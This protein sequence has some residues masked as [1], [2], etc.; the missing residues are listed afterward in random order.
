MQ[1]H[2][3]ENALVHATL[4]HINIM[5]MMTMMTLMLLMMMMMM[6]LVAAIPLIAVST[7]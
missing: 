5:V 6:M 1:R 7:F 4:I 2:Q 3:R